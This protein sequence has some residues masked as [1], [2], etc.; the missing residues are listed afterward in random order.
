MSFRKI[1]VLLLGFVTLVVV[2]INLK[3]KMG[4]FGEHL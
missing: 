2:W 1:V 4:V 3:R